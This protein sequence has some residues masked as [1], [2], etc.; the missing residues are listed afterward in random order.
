MCRK[1]IIE[2]LDKKIQ[3]LETNLASESDR[4]KIEKIH[5][6]LN[7]ANLE[8]QKLVDEKTKSAMFRCRTKWY[9]DGEKSSK[10]FFNLEKSNFNK[11]VMNSTYLPDGTLSKDP[12]KILNEQR[13]FYEKLY[14]SDE[15]VKF[16]IL[17]QNDP[18]ISDLDKNLVDKD[19][20][21]DDLKYALQQMPNN[22]TPGCDGLPAEFY[23]VFWNKIKDV[24]YEAIIYAYHSGEMH[25]S[26]RRGI[27]TLIP[28]K[29]KDMNY[30]KNWRPLTLLNTDYKILAKALAQRLKVKLLK[31][32]DK[33]QTGFL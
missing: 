32:I 20:T 19:I 8:L 4:Y 22:K 7:S 16:N 12:D 21:M 29:D 18:K 25:I 23:K 6:D 31:I 28:K 15:N 3:R 11:K 1:N 33:D 9:E 24:L 14:T 10:Y 13:K 2:V 27:I 30:I 5:K 17:N 26:A